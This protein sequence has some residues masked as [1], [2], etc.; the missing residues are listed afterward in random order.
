MSPTLSPPAE[1]LVVTRSPLAMMFAL[2]MARPSTDSVSKRLSLGSSLG[3]G[4]LAAL[5]FTALFAP[6]A[7]AQAAAA[8]PDQ[9]YKVNTRKG[10]VSAVP[11]TVTENSLEVVRY[12][13]DN[14]ELKLASEEVVKI[15]W[16]KVP[17]TF[18]DGLKYS[19]RGDHENAVGNFKLA[20]TDA[21]A[22]PVVKAAARFRAALEFFAWGAADP[23]QFTA[24][25]E[26]CDM[27]LSSYANDRHVPE[28]RKLRARALLL[29]GDA[30]AAADTYK[31]LY[32]EGA[33]DPPTKGYSREL[34]LNAGL[35]AAHA[36]L[37]T[38]DTLAARELFATIEGSLRSM[39][40]EIAD[41]RSPV[42]VRLVAAQGEAVVGE[43][44]CMLAGG[45]ASQAITFFQG[46]LSRATESAA[47][48]QAAS[49]GLAEAFLANGQNRLAQVEFARV[50]ATDPRGGDRAARALVGLANS[51]LRLQDKDAA[52]S[53]KTW[54]TL[55]KNHYGNTP[56]AQKAA[57]L[58]K[59]L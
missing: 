53:A 34:C 42:R 41:E 5:L 22:R 31:L 48:R 7:A 28:V 10:T 59:T 2:T 14:K 26:E 27:L 46:R 11:G 25:V 45:Q 40:A 32:A 29:S 18:E 1:L 6:Q 19:D 50:S 30:K 23:N 4:I 58:L 21:G 13:H 16:G 33:N 56:S 9:I 38:G 47:E 57:E 8:R 49:L 12:T 54:L 3:A 43:G 37:S 35:D 39:A 55:V 17:G 24:C 52:A 51:T 44:F 20:A 36:Y 15:V